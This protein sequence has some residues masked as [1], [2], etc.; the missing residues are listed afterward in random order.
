MR[1]PRIAKNA[2]P[3]QFVQVLC[4]DSCDPL[5]GGHSVFDADSQD[6]SI[7]FHTVGKGTKLLSKAKKGDF[8]SVLGPLGNGFLKFGVRSSKFGEY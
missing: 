7:L 5:L 1:S 8:F 2:K 3:G 4:A 6:L